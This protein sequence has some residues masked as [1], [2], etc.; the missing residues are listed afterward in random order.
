MS[1]FDLIIIGA[2]P[3][4]SAAAVTARRAG[5]TT[6]VID[7]AALPRAKLCG[8]LFTGR[9][10]HYYRDIFGTDLDPALFEPRERIAFHLGSTPLGAPEEILPMYL[11][12]R[13]DMDA[14]LFDL[15]RAAGVADFTGQRIDQLDP[16]ANRVTLADGRV[17]SYG[18]L[19]GADG[20]QSIVARALFGRPFDPDKI[21]FA[22]EVEAPAE[23]D[24]T[25]VRIDFDAA[26]W[27]YGWQFPKRGSTTIGIGG[28]QRHNAD[29]KAR[30]HQ[31]RARL[32]DDSA[33][34]VKG[35]FLPFGDYKKRPGRGNV[36]L[37]GDAAGFVDPITGEGI[38]YAL[39]S[40]Q[41]A[42]K[43]AATALAAAAPQTAIKGYQARIK[44][45]HQSLR[46]ACILRPLI[47]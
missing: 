32:D 29:M 45:I 35:H 4:G 6:A 14:H 33:P 12:M 37:A 34:R 9:A 3:A 10:R 36:L 42:A 8:G 5:L 47:F 15:A 31:Y 38:A 13:W 20:V 19:I 23:P 40:G 2:G 39:K 17:L 24:N 18:C 11:T 26:K 7:K 30:L 22:L 46:M 41:M 27:G 21:G 16:G 28:L 43:S 44:P 1:H 25:L